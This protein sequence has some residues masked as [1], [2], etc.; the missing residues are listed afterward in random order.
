MQIINR[1]RKQFNKNRPEIFYLNKKDYKKYR[2]EVG[3]LTKIDDTEQ[4]WFCGIPVNL[5]GDK[6]TISEIFKCK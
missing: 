6:R 5:E 3:G 1:L 2:V 4:L